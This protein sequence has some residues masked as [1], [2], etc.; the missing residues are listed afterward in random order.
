MRDLHGGGIE[1]GTHLHELG[2][3]VNAQL[4]VEVLRAADAGWDPPAIAAAALRRRPN[5]ERAAA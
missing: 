5:G 4:G 1:T 2:P 3:H